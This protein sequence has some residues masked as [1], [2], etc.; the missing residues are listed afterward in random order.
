MKDLI[1]K[2]L[3]KIGIQLKR[4]PDDDLAR[5]M[6]MINNFNIDTLFDIGAN[7]GQYSRN[8]RELGYRKK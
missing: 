7:E 4:Y 1:K 2:I 8:M 5:R 6:K 3:R